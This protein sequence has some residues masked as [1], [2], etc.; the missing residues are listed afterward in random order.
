MSGQ[1]SAAARASMNQHQSQIGSKPLSKEQIVNALM[2][3]T[4][5]KVTVYMQK[6]GTM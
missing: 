5:E 2:P 6:E 4:I 3:H 1:L